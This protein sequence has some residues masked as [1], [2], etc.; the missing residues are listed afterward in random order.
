MVMVFIFGY[1]YKKMKIVDLC[2]FICLLFFFEKLD[3]F[4]SGF[5]YPVNIIIPNFATA[6]SIGMV[7]SLLT[8]SVYL[9]KSKYGIFIVFFNLFI[10]PTL[11]L[12]TISY[13][14]LT[15]IF[16]KE[17]LNLFSL[18]TVCIVFLFLKYDTS[19]LNDDLITF[20]HLND[21]HRMPLNFQHFE[22][23]LLPFFLSLLNSNQKDL[24][25]EWVFIIICILTSYIYYN[26]EFNFFALPVLSL[27]PSRGVN[28]GVALIIIKSCI[29]LVLK[30]RLYKMSVVIFI[31]ILIY[32]LFII[33]THL[34]TIIIGC[35]T[36]LII[37][38]I[39]ILYKVEMKPINKNNKTI[40]MRG[41][42]LILILL[43]FIIYMNFKSAEVNI[44]QL[45]YDKPKAYDK[46]FQSIKEPSFYISLVSDY[47][48]PKRNKNM[49]PLIV[50]SSLDG[51]SY[52]PKVFEKGNQIFKTIFNKNLWEIDSNN[53]ASF[54]YHNGGSIL[55]NYNKDDWDKVRNLK[56]KYLICPMISKINLERVWE[57]NE[58]VIFK[59]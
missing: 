21:I 44:N 14:L 15:A 3:L 50:L 45:V 9:W 46:Y 10:H 18:I 54:K 57:D 19:F 8:I 11:G 52:N 30:P 29:D 28:I 53:S 26:L 1:F 40:K 22:F 48:I 55:E 16:K 4:T 49:I 27:M 38:S 37:L 34:T 51:Y 25:V 33:N 36:G 39:G 17:Y 5:N 43:S 59:L 2:F 41:E 24:I 47:S 13:L 58:Y 20:I 35:I 56:L 7:S 23:L 6:G 31:S 42:Y 32:R 12:L